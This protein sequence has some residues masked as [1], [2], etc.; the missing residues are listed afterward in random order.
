M[1]ERGTHLGEDAE[2]YALGCLSAPERATV[3]SHVRE[4]AE[5]L[6]RVGE[7]EETLLALERQNR[8]VRLA[9]ASAA[10][11]PFARRGISAW[12]LAPAMAAAFAFGLLFWHGR[13]AHDDALLAMVRSHFNHAQFTGDGA[14]AKLIYARD[15]SWYYVIVS[16]AGEYSVYGMRNGAAKLLGVTRSS[17]TAS[18]LF[19]RSSLSFDRIELRRQGQPIES[20]AI[21]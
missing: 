5:C 10:A 3:E 15:R 21:R 16:G 9:A 20:A 1:T 2:L 11:L 7:A 14:P 8:A 17:G 19:V 4:C 18:E 12:W 6:R 13:P